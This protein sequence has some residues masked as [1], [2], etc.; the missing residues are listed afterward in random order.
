MSSYLQEVSSHSVPSAQPLIKAKRDE[1]YELLTK[2]LVDPILIKTLQDA[3]TSKAE[4]TQVQI[5]RMGELS[6][7]LGLAKSTIYKMIV[8]EKFPKG[9]SIN[10]GKA[11]GWLSTTID[12][13]LEEKAA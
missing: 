12:Q 4:N 3:L 6:K 5:I 10:G 1:L 2:F 8:E 13:W 9:F 11:T 7:R